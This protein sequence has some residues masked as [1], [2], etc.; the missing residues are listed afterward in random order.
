M[1]FQDGGSGE[2]KT[3]REYLTKGQE[4]K[5][6]LK[7]DPISVEELFPDGNKP[8]APRK[9]DKVEDMQ[10]AITT[11]INKQFSEGRPLT[12]Q[13]LTLAL[14]FKTR[15]SL[16]DYEGY[17]D[18]EDIPFLNT[19]KRAKLFVENYKVEGALSGLL[20]PTTVIFDL[21]NNSGY[22]DKTEVEIEKSKND[23]DDEEL[24]EAIRLRLERLSGE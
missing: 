2:T 4:K 9:Y 5:L 6:D 22:K 19:I 7:R 3:E 23:F 11:Y 12:I 24:D 20:N 8:H 18:D 16:L 15:K 13:G 14:G 10:A 1:S 17:T 21:K